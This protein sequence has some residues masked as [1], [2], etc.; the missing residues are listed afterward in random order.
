MDNKYL[1]DNRQFLIGETFVHGDYG[2]G[3]C[4][5]IEDRYITID[6][7]PSVGIK[8][9]QFPA[10]INHYIK[11]SEESSLMDHIEERRKI[12]FTARASKFLHTRNVQYFV[13]FTKVKNIDSIMNN[14]ICSINE[15]C[16]KN[17]EYFGNDDV[18]LDGHKD[19]VSLSISFP[20]YKNFYYLRQIKGITDEYC[21]IG[22]NAEKVLQLNCAFFPTNAASSTCRNLKWTDMSTENA[23]EAL[24]TDRNRDKTIPDFYSTDPQ[25]EVMVKDRIPPDYIEWIAFEH[26]IPDDYKKLNDLFVVEPEYFSYRMDYERWKSDKYYITLD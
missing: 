6:F 8:E 18:R 21:I 22:I 13:H 25:A 11:W 24:F 3:K 2:S 5:K 23:L 10:A 26:R 7:G 20:N 19:A 4:I 15:L 14:G 16:A 12:I 9:F 1:R 17:I